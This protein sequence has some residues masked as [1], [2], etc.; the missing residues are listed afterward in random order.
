MDECA[1]IDL[2]NMF[3]FATLLL[4]FIGGLLLGYGYF[5]ALRKTAKLIVDHGHPALGLGLTLGR[6][7]LLGAG[8]YI[9]VLA[10][11]LALLAALAGV[12]CAKALILRQ[13]RRA[14]T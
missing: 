1:M 8:F 10:S 7:A 11:G 6:L 3:P 12:L 14:N 4:C 2:Y 13:L 5:S 9:A